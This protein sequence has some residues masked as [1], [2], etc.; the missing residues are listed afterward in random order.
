MF[1]SLRSHERVNLGDIKKKWC[2]FSSPSKSQAF[3]FWLNCLKTRSLKDP[4]MSGDKN[5]WIKCLMIS[6]VLLDTWK[7]R[8]TRTGVFRYFF[9]F[10]PIKWRSVFFYGG[11]DVT[12][13]ISCTY[14]STDRKF[15][16]PLW[17]LPRSAL[18]HIMSQLSLS[19]A[20][21][22]A[23]HFKV[24]QTECCRCYMETAT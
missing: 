11:R 15:S 1:E 19:V 12:L 4:W 17:H 23:F 20:F 5:H 9:K 13:P 21:F 2:S 3:L 16:C 22:K 18:S 10:I 6:V 24:Q 8:K 14:I 7:K